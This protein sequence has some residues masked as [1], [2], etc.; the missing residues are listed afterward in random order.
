MSLPYKIDKYKKSIYIEND[1]INF[2]T[3]IQKEIIENKL[4]ILN[5]K[6]YDNI[7]TNIYFPNNPIEEI[8]YILPKPISTVGYRYKKQNFNNLPKKLQ[9]LNL[10]LVDIDCYKMDNLPS[11]LKKLYLPKSYCYELD[12]L[13]LEIEELI[14]HVNNNFIQSLDY[15]PESLKKLMII[16]QK[17]DEKVKL[18]CDNLPSGLE[19]LLL[20]GNIDCELNNLPR[21]LNTL[22]LTETNNNMIYNLP[23]KLEVLSLPINYKYL[24]EIRSSTNT[25]KLKKL[26]IENNYNYKNNLRTITLFDLESIPDSIEEIDFGDNFN[27]PLTYLPLGLKKIIFGFNFNFSISLNLPDSIEYLEFGYNFNGY[28]SKYPANLKILKF[29]RNFSSR[30]DNLPHGLLELEINERFNNKLL[31]LPTTLE[32]LKFNEL[33]EYSNLDK[34]ELP[35]SIKI[36][37]V[38]KN[39]NLHNIKNIPKSLEYIKYNKL[40]EKITKLIEKTGWNGKIKYWN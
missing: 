8:I 10:K 40:N 3:N 13:P 30:I 37:Q 2:L 23:D 17:Y 4:R 15:L 1:Y 35:D 21:N 12:N 20:N 33:S 26:I 6:S 5:Y 36:L 19:K 9:I 24:R 28:I 34:L 31:N 22:Y 16:S 7:G 11:G 29:G 14:L 32:I 38:G 25:V 39:P 27:Q 18:N